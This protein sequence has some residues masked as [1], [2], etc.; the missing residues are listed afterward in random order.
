M[1]FGL[2]F[3]I[4]SFEVL[5]VTDSPMNAFGDVKYKM[6]NACSLPTSICSWWTTFFFAA[7]SLTL[8]PTPPS[9]ITATFGVTLVAVAIVVAVVVTASVGGEGGVSVPPVTLSILGSVEGATMLTVIGGGGLSDPHSAA[10]MLLI[11]LWPL[12]ALRFILVICHD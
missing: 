7:N 5:N 9:P 10:A 11:A 4:R 8:G 3:V 2:K 12:A 1:I 6:H